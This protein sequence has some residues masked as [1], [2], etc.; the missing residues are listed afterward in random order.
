MTQTPRLQPAPNSPT[1]KGPTFKNPN[2]K[3][4]GRNDDDRLHQAALAVSTRQIARE[5]VRGGPKSVKKDKRP[6][7]HGQKG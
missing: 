5:A 4:N 6:T 3:G 7:G 1:P 2:T